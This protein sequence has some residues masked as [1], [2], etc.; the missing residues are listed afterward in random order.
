MQK[1]GSEKVAEKLAGAGGPPAKVDPV[2]NVQ[3]WLVSM[4]DQLSMAL[5]KHVTADRI[6]RL[7]LT[8]VRRNP[9]L[10]RCSKE[11]L[12]GAIMQSAQLGLEPGIGNQAHIIPYKNKGRM[13]AQFQIGYEGYIDLMY[14]NPRVE[15]I[16]GNVVY[17][18]DF[19][20]AEYGTADK[21]VHRPLDKDRGVP[22]KY[23]VYVKLKGAEAIYLVMSKED[24]KRHAKQY[25]KAFGSEYSPYKTSFD[26]MALKTCVRQIQRWIPKS[27]ELRDAESRDYS[28]R[29][30]IEDTFDRVDF[31]V[32]D[33]GGA[34]VAAE[35]TPGAEAPAAETAAPA[36]DAQEKMEM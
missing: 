22:V 20:E 5:P 9:E 27:I 31:E 33:E 10:L 12:L 29:P 8:V 36:G 2:R 6:I 19:F 4:K 21:F 7:A 34:A 30:G 3:S 18:N 23:Y 28:V 25:S 16:F 1:T 32:V 35:E 15:K 17:E 26:A 24:V 13:E 14:R 11:S